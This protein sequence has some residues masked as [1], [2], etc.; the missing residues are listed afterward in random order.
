MIKMKTLTQRLSS[1]PRSI[2]K[3]IAVAGIAAFMAGCIQYF[4][5]YKATS[6][7]DIVNQPAAYDKQWIN[8]PGCI[9]S[10]SLEHDNYHDTTIIHLTLSDD[11]GRIITAERGYLSEGIAANIEKVIAAISRE[12]NDKDTEQSNVLGEYSEENGMINMHFIEIE[13]TMYPVFR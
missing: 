9:T 11:E 3:A 13:G 1:I 2:G 6:V 8:T 5:E 7:A 10:I 4:Y 12:A